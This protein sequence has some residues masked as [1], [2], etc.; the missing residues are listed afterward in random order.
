MWIYF[1][2]H[3]NTNYARCVT[4]RDRRAPTASVHPVAVPPLTRCALGR[5]ALR[6]KIAPPRLQGKRVGLFSTVRARLRVARARCAS[7]RYRLGRSRSLSQL[8]RAP[9]DRVPSV[10]RTGPTT[11]ASPLRFLL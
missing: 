8:L 9:A 4:R 1:V 7:A 5:S 10:P 3:E 11:L 2:F 6:A